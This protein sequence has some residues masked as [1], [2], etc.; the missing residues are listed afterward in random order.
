MRTS[1]IGF[2]SLEETPDVINQLYITV[3]KVGSSETSRYTAQHKQQKLFKQV[4]PSPLH[5]NI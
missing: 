5:K 3:A 1:Y 2:V 4:Y